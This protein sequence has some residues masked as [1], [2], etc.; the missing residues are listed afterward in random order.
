MIP[1][2]TGAAQAVSLV[3]PQLKGK[4]SG[5]SMRV[6]TPTVSVV[7]LVV[8]TK[9]PVTIEAVNE[10]LKIASQ[11][12]MKGILGYSEEPL[13]STDYK[14][15]KRSSIVDALSTDVLG[16][17]M[18]KVIAWYDNEWGYAERVVD[19]CDYMVEKSK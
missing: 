5:M 7:D 19:L 4:F 6:P 11:G 14:G 12:E 3:L 1:T 9:K 10:A 17:K 16:E 18:V 15:D 2:T 8:T 13:V